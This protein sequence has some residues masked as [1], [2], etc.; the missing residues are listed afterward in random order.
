MGDAKGALD[1]LDRAIKLQEA[2]EQ[3]GFGAALRAQGGGNGDSAADCY[4]GGCDIGGLSQGFWVGGPVGAQ[5][6]C[7][8]ACLGQERSQAA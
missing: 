7:C 3:M 2:A 4:Q 5:F 6:L 1:D 8:G